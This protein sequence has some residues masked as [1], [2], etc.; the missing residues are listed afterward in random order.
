MLDQ[1]IRFGAILAQPEFERG[2]SL[3]EVGSGSQGI[4]AFIEDRVVG[5]DIAFAEKP[6]P[7]LIPIKASATHLPLRDASFDHVVSSDMLEHLPPEQRGDAIAE[8][9]R[10]TRSHLFLACPCDLDARK[11]DARLARLYRFIGIASPA[12]LED[13]L[14]K[15]I[16]DA[17]AIRAVLEEQKTTWREIAGESGAGHFFVSLL[18]SSK[19]LNRFWSTVFRR[20]PDRARAVAR[21]A[22][23]GAGKGYRKL[24][25]VN[26]SLT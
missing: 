21:F 9:L 24:W 25:I 4:S 17:A 15:I 1:A 8:L 2:D 26:K 11:I 19:I 22:S 16:P 10:V 18:I 3:L 23:L 6:A 12:W 5:I 14:S 7:A 20:R 13:H